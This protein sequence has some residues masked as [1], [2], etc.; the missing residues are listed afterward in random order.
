MLFMLFNI[1]QSNV[2]FTVSLEIIFYAFTGYVVNGQVKDA[3]AK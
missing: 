1:R 3:N 2:V